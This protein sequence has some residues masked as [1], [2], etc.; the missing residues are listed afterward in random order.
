MNEC[1][2][3]HMDIKDANILY[4][5]SQLFLIDFSLLTKD[6]KL[7]Y[8]F[9]LYFDEKEVG[10]DKE[11]NLTVNFPPESNYFFMLGDL[12]LSKNLKR[13]GEK[14]KQVDLTLK[15]WL[16]WANK[17]VPEIYKDHM[18][19][20]KQLKKLE[21]FS[22]ER[23]VIDREYKDL[24]VN[25]MKIRDKI[26]LECYEK[27]KGPDG[28][29]I[30]DDTLLKCLKSA[31]D[32]FQDIFLLYADRYDSY[33]L[34][35]TVL[36]WIRT[37][38]EKFYHHLDEEDKHIFD[39]FALSVYEHLCAFNVRHRMN[40]TDFHKHFLRQIRFFG[41]RD[42][43]Q[44]YKHYCSK[45]YKK[46]KDRVESNENIKESVRSEKLC[47]KNLFSNLDMLMD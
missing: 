21:R 42:F 17:Y 16:I 33:R 4:N 9:V 40:L 23:F 1:G 7:D 32:N 11:L 5:D 44:E 22:P 14:Y 34:G 8:N 27:F 43:L 20:L 35:C 46:R 15:D 6:C 18:F 30:H 37:F 45:I 38:R 47:F 13:Q 41:Y 2:Y 10:T 25:R 28:K 36:S 3:F 31:M 39:S 24:L 29:I 12:G 19:Y 26:Y